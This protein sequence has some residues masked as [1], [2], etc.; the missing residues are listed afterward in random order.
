MAVKV[1]STT[2]P[3]SP[4]PTFTIS[5]LTANQAEQIRDL[6][7]RVQDSDLFDVYTGLSAEL[8][9]PKRFLVVYK[10][11]SSGEAVVELEE[12]V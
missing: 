10:S 4:P 11:M 8:S 9:S 5:G 2:P 6:I 7:G 12:I 1:T 3:P